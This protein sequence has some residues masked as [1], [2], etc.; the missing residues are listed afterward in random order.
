M[1]ST[2]E[3]V[4]KGVSMKR[5]PGAGRSFWRF[6]PLHSW[7]N[8][9]NCL[10]S[11]HTLIRWR[12]FLD[13]PRE[14]KLFKKTLK[15]CLF[16]SN[17][18]FPTWFK[19]KFK[20]REKKGNLRKLVEKILNSRA[21]NVLN[22]WERRKLNLIVKFQIPNLV[23]KSSNQSENWN[24]PQNWLAKLNQKHQKVDLF[25]NIFRSKFPSKKLLRT[26]ARKF[27]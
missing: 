8:F 21:Q 23:S 25:F 10:T 26:L 27:D 3:K 2:N 19:G 16:Y 14:A 1:C 17:M 24:F 7:S 20:Y 12:H 13:I 11:L 22:G 5:C 9:T 15:L 18:I 4:M 6:S